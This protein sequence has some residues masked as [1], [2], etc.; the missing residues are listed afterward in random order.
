MKIFKLLLYISFFSIIFTSCKQK[1]DDFLHLAIPKDLQFI[2][3]K[4]S[5]TANKNG[6]I[7]LHENSWEA[8]SNAMNTIDGCEIDIQ[9]SA[10]S[11]F[12][13]FHSERILDCNDSLVN[14]SFFSDE[15][16]Q[17]ISDCNYNSSIIKFSEFLNKAK[18]EDWKE[19]ILCLDMKVFYNPKTL[20]LFS[21]NITLTY[22]VRD[23]LHRLINDSKVETKVI[24]EVFTPYQYK[25]FDS[26]FKDHTN[27]VDIN[28]SSRSIIANNQSNILLSLPFHEMPEDFDKSIMSFENLWPIN[29]P[30]DFF[31]GIKFDPKII[32][33]D[34]IPLMQFFKSLQENNALR[35]IS[36]KKEIIKTNEEYNSILILDFPI[37]ENQ[38]INFKN[39]SDTFPDEVFLVYM[40]I[41]ENETAVHWEAVE[42]N[43]NPEIFYFINPEFL[44]SKN[45]KRAYINIWN[46]DKSNLDHEFSIQQY[47]TR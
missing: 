14:F 1:S 39:L 26:I 42:L 3:H 10:D 46:K 23:N 27:L 4:G 38:L 19:K 9:L 41:D 40:A 34:N 44:S 7:N 43:E 5:G 35:R 18:H 25:V 31:E 2:G 37:Q 11:T 13:I 47:T 33:S 8:I 30:N 17:E 16:I 21:D 12:W 28:P 45:A 36:S 20:R 6:N 22:F 29:N 32:Q 15:N 24:L